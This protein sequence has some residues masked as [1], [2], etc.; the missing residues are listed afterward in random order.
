MKIIKPYDGKIT[1]IEFCCNDMAYAILENKIIMT[2]NG[3][4]ELPI[5]FIFKISE[6]NFSI[7]Y[8]PHCGAKIEVLK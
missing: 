3:G 4:Y 6:S 1:G 8:C 2:E 5:D 7:K